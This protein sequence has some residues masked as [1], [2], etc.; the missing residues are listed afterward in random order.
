MI[1]LT[2]NDVATLNQNCL[3]AGEPFGI[4]DVNRLESALGNQYAPYEHDEQVIASVFRSIIQNHAFANGN[5]RT[6]VLVMQ[7]LADSIDAEVRLSDQEL[8][9]F[10]Y[11][12]ADAGGSSISVNTIANKLFGTEFEESLKEAVEKHDELNPKLF[13]ENKKLKSK[14]RDKIFAV[15]NDFIEGLHHTHSI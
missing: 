2:A 10:V 8:C 5:K 4:L 9:D 14:V 7:V 15:T 12:L 11:K 13:D 6:A 1:I 3:R